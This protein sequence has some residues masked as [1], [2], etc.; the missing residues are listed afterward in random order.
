MSAFLLRWF[1]LIWL[2]TRGH[3]ALVL[4]NLAL[5]QQLAVY[6]R[7]S[8]RPRLNRSERAFWITLASVWNGWRR[9]LVL[10]HPDTVVRWQRQR[11]CRY[12]AQLSGKPNGKVGRPSIGKLVR[13][14]V[15]TMV[16]ANPLWRAPRIHGELL[17]L[18][19]KISE[20]TELVP[21]PDIMLAQ[22][23]ST[24]RLNR[25]L[26]YMH[27]RTVAQNFDYVT[28]LIKAGLGVKC[29]AC[30]SNRQRSHSVK[31]I[32]MTKPAQPSILTF[33]RRRWRSGRTTICGSPKIA[34]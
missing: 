32:I 28:N 20:R 4:E 27:N 2:F 14:L 19:I 13:N 33:A 22:G 6:K 24:P 11:F 15:E 30:D 18:C 1:R 16:Q 34:A 26:Y 31:E 12:W 17:K 3:Q 21:L 7:N 8:K 23:L 29:E 10:V 5:R 9:V 25:F